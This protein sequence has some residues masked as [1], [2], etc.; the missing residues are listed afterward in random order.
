MIPASNEVVSSLKAYSLHR[1]CSICM[2]RFHNDLEEDGASDEVKCE[3]SPTS[4]E[5]MNVERFIS[6]MT[7]KPNALRFWVKVWCPTHLG[8]CPRLN[9]MIPRPHPTMVPESIRLFVSKVV[10]EKAS[11]RGEAWP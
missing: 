6:E 9:V 5:T 3:L 10:D 8:S 4:G 2:E 11:I 1:N 7:H